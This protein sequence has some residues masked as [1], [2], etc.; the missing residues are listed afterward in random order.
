MKAK[1]QRSEK[2]LIVGSALLAAVL[3]G[4]IVVHQRLNNAP[5]AVI[6]TNALPSPN[7]YDFYV[8]AS[9]AIPYSKD[10]SDTKQQY[11]LPQR[12]QFVAANA[13]NLKVLRQGL[14]HEF[15][16]AR[17]ALSA[18]T[19]F[20]E[21]AG[22]RDMARLLAFEG[23]LRADQG[24]WKGATESYLDTI[25]LG[26]DVPHGSVLIGELSGLA[27]EAIGRRPA[28]KAA[29]NVSAAD[30]RAAVRR[31]DEIEAH[32]YPFANT[33]E[34]EKWWSQAMFRELF[35]GTTNLGVVT[36]GGGSSNGGGVNWQQMGQGLFM[37][38]QIARYG[39]RQ[40]LE[41][42]A[43]YWDGEIARV[44]QPYAAHPPATPLPTDV[45]NQILVPTFTKAYTKHVDA[46]TQHRLLTL[47]F[48]LRAYRLEHG[49]YPATLDEL[50]KAKIL[51]EVPGDPFALSQPLRYQRKAGDTYTLYSIGPDGKDDNGKSIDNKDKKG[52]QKLFAEEGTTGD[53][54]VGIN[55]N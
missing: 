9:N 48:A 44:K 47:V 38:V 45:L 30:A 36:G 53:F 8:Q 34:Q 24:N 55:T 3:V 40:I 49:A 5:D 39:K 42:N 1:W 52:E 43:N 4:F 26:H 32:R 22:F 41:N 15:V 13:E 28:W 29:R 20:P 23:N 14:K 17:P 35:R 6:P 10:I 7:A 12:K 51:Q 33:L 19:M 25:R 46:Q 27:C 11:T 54:V 37:N 50:V 21:Y 31:L 16:Y 2:A 18:A